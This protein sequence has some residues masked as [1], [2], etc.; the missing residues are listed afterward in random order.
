M[1]HENR[2]QGR[3]FQAGSTDSAKALRWEQAWHLN[4]KETGVTA[5]RKVKR[6]KV[7]GNDSGR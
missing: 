2:S 5:V 1:K 4:R 7:V 6:E 3:G